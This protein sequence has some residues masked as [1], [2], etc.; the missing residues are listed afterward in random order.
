LN[1]STPVD[2]FNE[3]EA[4]A[5]LK[6]ARQATDGWRVGTYDSTKKRRWTSLPLPCGD[7]RS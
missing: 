2:F 4:V 5:R 1:Q 7:L 6:A 3:L